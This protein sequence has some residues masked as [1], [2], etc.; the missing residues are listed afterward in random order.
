MFQ[1]RRPSTGLELHVFETRRP[2]TGIEV[3]VFETRCHTGQDSPRRTR[4]RS[5]S[6]RHAS[7][8][9]IVSR[10]RLVKLT[11]VPSAPHCVGLLC[12]ATMEWK[13]DLMQN[14]YRVA[15]IGSMEK[16]KDRKFSRQALN[17]THPLEYRRCGRR[18]R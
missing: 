14:T 9:V 1:T 16:E 4:S 18:E 10:L 7:T 5:S 3:H 12:G 11:W 2:R 17:L 6:A 15:S 13:M 8:V